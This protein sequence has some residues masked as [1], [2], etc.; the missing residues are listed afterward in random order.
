M[1]G[2]KGVGCSAVTWICQNN[3]ESCL[4]GIPKGHQC[5]PP[6]H[7]ETQVRQQSVVSEEHLVVGLHSSVCFEIISTLILHTVAI[8]Y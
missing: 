6:V 8:D 7:V 4:S 1:D 2:V 5:T 3:S